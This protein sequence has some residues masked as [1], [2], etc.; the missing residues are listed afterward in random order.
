MRLI[1]D[2]ATLMK[3]RIRGNTIRIRLSQ[4]EMI[5]LVG[6]GLVQDA[7][8]FGPDAR[9]DYRVAVVPEGAVRASYRSD[10]IDVALPRAA[11]DRWQRPE[12]VSVRAEQALDDGRSLT[13]LV[14]KDFACLS[15][16]DAEED[17]TDLFPNPERPPA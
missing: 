10:C 15:P 1:D 16:R 14:E 11:I 4:S 8:E 12:E 5:R 6:T 3:L 2:R 9:L 17:E 7:V 13:I